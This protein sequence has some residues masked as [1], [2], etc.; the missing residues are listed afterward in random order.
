MQTALQFTL[1]T[2]STII[3][4]FSCSQLGVNEIVNSRSRPLEKSQI[5]GISGFN[6]I[7][8]TATD[9]YN[10]IVMYLSDVNEFLKV[11]N[12][13]KLYEPFCNFFGAGYR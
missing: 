8:F 5:N 3:A 4:V 7:S 13:I 11:L 1:L 10:A 6:L 12:V 9:K 2:F